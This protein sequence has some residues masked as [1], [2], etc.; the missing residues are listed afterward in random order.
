MSVRKLD[1]QKELTKSE[2]NRRKTLEEK[3]K[4]TDSKTVKTLRDDLDSALKAKETLRS[5]INSIFDSGF[6]VYFLKE[7]SKFGMKGINVNWNNEGVDYILSSEFYSLTQK[8]DFIKIINAEGEIDDAKLSDITL[9]EQYTELFEKISRY[10]QR[11]EHLA[12]LRRVWK[13]VSETKR[14][15]DSRRSKQLIWCGD[16]S[17]NCYTI[18]T[19]FTPGEPYC[20]ADKKTT[21]DSIRLG[22]LS[23][24]MD[25]L[26]TTLRIGI[27]LE[28]KISRWKK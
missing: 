9:S 10:M 16:Y 17:K 14:T 4:P 5:Y 27:G 20:S 25:E 22:L 28:N 24:F 1:E 13:D 2:T 11:P 8:K 21:Y 19:G 6:L 18:C 3:L 26:C 23:G 15:L 7:V 12:N